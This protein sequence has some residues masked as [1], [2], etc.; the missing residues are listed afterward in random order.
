MSESLKGGWEGRR[1]CISGGSDRS[2]AKGERG[3]KRKKKRNTEDS[4]GEIPFFQRNRNLRE[5]DVQNR[6]DRRSSREKK[7]NEP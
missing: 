3:K 6:E 4:R 2:Q 1:I 7:T 5:N